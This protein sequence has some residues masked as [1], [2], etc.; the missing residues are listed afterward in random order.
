MLVKLRGITMQH[1]YYTAF[2]MGFRTF[3]RIDIVSPLIFFA[4]GLLLI[5]FI[6]LPK[7]RL[8]M[9]AVIIFEFFIFVL[10]QLMTVIPNCVSLRHAYMNS[11]SFTV[12]GIV[13]NFT[14]APVLGSPTESFR[15]GNVKFS[16]NKYDETPCL[17][18]SH[19][20]GGRI[21]NGLNV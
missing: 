16:Y 20:H 8:V 14:P 6:K 3:P 21:E 10:G 1:S 2:E 12:N 4:I 17:H 15:V 5:K 13:E 11:K 18:S 19:M 9:G 7:F